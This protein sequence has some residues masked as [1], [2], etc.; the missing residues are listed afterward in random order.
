MFLVSQAWL[1]AACECGKRA[2]SFLRLCCGAA[3]NEIGEAGAVAVAKALE[4]G[5]CK[6]TSLNVGG[7][8]GMADRTTRRFG[9]E[10][11]F[12]LQRLWPSITYIAILY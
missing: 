3:G 1:C 4:S 5:N 10:N 7:E 8:L 12:D 9:I 11:A 6:L 2:D